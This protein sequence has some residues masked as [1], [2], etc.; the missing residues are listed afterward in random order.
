MHNQEPNFSTQT[1]AVHKTPT[2]LW[3]SLGGLAHTEYAEVPSSLLKLPNQALLFSFLH[4]KKKEVVKR[5]PWTR[6]SSVTW[7]HRQPRNMH[8]VQFREYI[9]FQNQ[10]GV[11]SS[12]TGWLVHQCA[13]TSCITWGPLS[14]LLSS[15]QSTQ[16][17]RVQSDFKAIS[18]STKEHM[19]KEKAA[20]VCPQLSCQEGKG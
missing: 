10:G 4:G 19:A 8:L 13:T 9:V 3:H 17:H 18:F 7:R 11:S 6:C 1:G 5:Q 15:G 12:F 20:G 2:A 16:H 14:S